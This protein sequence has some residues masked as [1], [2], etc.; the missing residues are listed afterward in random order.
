MEHITLG[1]KSSSPDV[2]S[3]KKQFIQQKRKRLRCLRHHSLAALW[4]KG[5]YFLTLTTGDGS[6][7]CCIIFLNRIFLVNF[8]SVCLD[9]ESSKLWQPLCFMDLLCLT[10]AVFHCFSWVHT[11]WKI[12]EKKEISLKHSG[13]AW[14]EYSVCFKLA[15]LEIDKV[16]TVNLFAFKFRTRV[17]TVQYCGFRACNGTIL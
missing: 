17:H 1:W 2:C 10:D 7:N 12:V 3:K 6:I 15:K 11:T 8:I 14:E 4:N 9:R 13:W 16:L 5:S